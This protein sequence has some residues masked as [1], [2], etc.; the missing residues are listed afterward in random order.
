MKT[1]EFINTLKVN[2]DKD[3]LFEYSENKFAGKN[4]HVTEVKNVQFE[5]IDCGGNVNNWKETQLQIWESPTETNKKEYLTTTKVLSILEKVNEIKPLWLDTQIKI[6]FGNANFHTS[7]LKIKNFQLN[8]EQL[9]V[10]LT[11]EETRCK[12]KETCGIED[13]A[14]CESKEEPIAS[15]C[16]G[17]DCC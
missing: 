1:Q 7:V 12:A 13:D 2:K 4:Y 16:E 9:I 8:K 10:K 14:C 3:L 15:C 11:T 5:T 6:E 17:S